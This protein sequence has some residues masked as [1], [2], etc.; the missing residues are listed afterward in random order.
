MNSNDYKIVLLSAMT[1]ITNPP[2][3]RRY[4][5]GVQIDRIGIK[6]LSANG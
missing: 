2:C 1:R 3:S 5:I 4:V 6:K